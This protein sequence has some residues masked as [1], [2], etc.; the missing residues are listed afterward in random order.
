MDMLAYFLIFFIGI[1]V[2]FINIVSAGGSLIALPALI[3]FGLPSQTANGTNRVA[4]FFQNLSAIYEFNRHGLLRWKLSILVAIPTTIGSI[5]GAK[6]AVDLPDEIFNRIL[7]I[8]MILVLFVIFIKPQKYINQEREHL[9]K[10]MYVTLCIIFFFI[11]IYGGVIQAAVGFLF[12]IAFRI[13]MPTLSYAEI[14]SLKT[15][16]ITIYLLI[17][18]VIFVIEGHV[19]LGYVVA[20][21]LGNVIGAYYG[22]KFTATVK[23]KYLNI[24][25]AVIVIG[26]AIKLLVDSL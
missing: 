6:F 20:L 3:F 10:L 5:V 22:G 18:T 23:E 16:I 19:H 25:M 4:I 12:I 13:F 14:Q 7:A 8:V 24:V 9:T 17:S 11:G 15:M 26:L 1:F 2:G 21:G